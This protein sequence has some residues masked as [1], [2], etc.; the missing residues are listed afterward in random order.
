MFSYEDRMKAVNLLINYDL[1]YTAVM[2]EQVTP[3]TEFLEIGMRNTCKQE[4]SIKKK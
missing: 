4:I 2:R 1:N 3:P